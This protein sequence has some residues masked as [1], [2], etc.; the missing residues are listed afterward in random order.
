MY[1]FRGSIVL[2]GHSNIEEILNDQ[3]CVPRI[4]QYVEYITP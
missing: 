1:G 4:D 2:S 3:N